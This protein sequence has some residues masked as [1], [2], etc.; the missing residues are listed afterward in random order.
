[1]LAQ[2]T[3]E[4]MSHFSPTQIPQQWRVPRNV[5]RL[6]RLV[7]LST[8]LLMRGWG[9][10][11]QLQDITSFLGIRRACCGM[12]CCG[13]GL[14]MRLVSCLLLQLV[15]TS[16]FAAKHVSGKSTMFP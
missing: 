7:L 10:A 2:C 15:L 8:A 11:R 16:S 4:H 14:G 6:Q 12:K 3:D 13:E 5:Y 9:T 1:M